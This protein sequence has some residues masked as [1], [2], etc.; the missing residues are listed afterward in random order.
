MIFGFGTDIT[1]VERIAKKLE[2]NPALFTHIFSQSEI[3]YC[4]KQSI[5]AQSFAA[6]FAV[7]EAFLK[8]YGV[9]F[10]GNHHLPEI[11]VQNTMH[12]KPSIILHGKTLETFTAKALGNIWVSI[13]HTAQYAMASVIIEK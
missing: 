1:E 13:S 9:T 2:N 3:D 8:A 4:N 7:K 10:I 11:E 6:R 12:G 5:P